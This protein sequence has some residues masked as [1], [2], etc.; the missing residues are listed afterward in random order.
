L[1]SDRIGE[2]DAQG[3]DVYT[4]FNNDGSGNAVRDAT[5]LLRHLR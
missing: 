2:W 1:W 5:T 4:Y 3:R